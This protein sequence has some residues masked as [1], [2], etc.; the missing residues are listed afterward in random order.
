MTVQPFPKRWAGLIDPRLIDGETLLHTDV[1][2]HNF[3]ICGTK[4]WVVDWSMPSRGAAWIDTAL[5]VVRL[6]RAGHD[7]ADA[8]AWARRLPA[9]ATA[10]PPTLEAFACA[11]A[12][13]TRL[14]SRTNPA[15]HRTGS[16]PPPAAGRTPWRSRAAWGCPAPIGEGGGQFRLRRR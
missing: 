16:R 2:P 9:W 3:L 5:M 14:R 4:V 11:L 10:T 8:Q 13:L 7:P 6:I 12:D 15:P 1:T